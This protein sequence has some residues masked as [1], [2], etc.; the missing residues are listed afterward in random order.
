M[1]RRL[2][3]WNKGHSGHPVFKD[4]KAE[5][6]VDQI[7]VWLSW[8]LTC[9]TNEMAW[10]DLLDSHHRDWVLAGDL[11]V[12]PSELSVTCTCVTHSHLSAVHVLNSLGTQLLTFLRQRTPVNQERQSCV[13]RKHQHMAEISAVH[14][15]PFA[16]KRWQVSKCST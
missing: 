6:G 10:Y 12:Q 3:C 1:A 16:A 4:I 5:T 11:E 9:S 2:Q 14:L 15:E 13:H 8:L 7:F